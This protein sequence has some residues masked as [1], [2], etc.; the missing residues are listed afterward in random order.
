MEEY[1]VVLITAP[2]KEIGKEI[3]NALL[4]AKLAAC[5]NIISSIS[6][7]YSWDGEICDDEEAL[8]IVKTRAELIENALIPAVEEIHPYKVPE[9]IALPIVLGARNYL[10]WI[11]EMTR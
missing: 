6:S 10:E 1:V 4:E 2:S 5:V 11:G 9:I 7:L 3:A 8:L